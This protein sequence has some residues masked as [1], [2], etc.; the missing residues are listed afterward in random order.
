MTE[1]KLSAAP[2]GNGFQSTVS[3]PNGVSMNSAETYPTVSEALAAAALKLI[4]MPDRLAA[5]DQELTAPKD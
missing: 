3:F 1:V 4:D 5:F 2:R